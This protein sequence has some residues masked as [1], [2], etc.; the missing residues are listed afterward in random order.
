MYVSISRYEAYS[1]NPHSELG[2]ISVKKYSLSK[3]SELRLKMKIG[4]ECIGNEKVEISSF[5]QIKRLK[6][7]FDDSFQL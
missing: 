2:Q 6:R 7:E 1:D 3:D 4:M 5:F